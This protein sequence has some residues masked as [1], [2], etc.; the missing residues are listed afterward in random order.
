M[1]YLTKRSNKEIV[2][3]FDYAKSERTVGG[4]CL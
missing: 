3:P 2:K 4:N 1:P